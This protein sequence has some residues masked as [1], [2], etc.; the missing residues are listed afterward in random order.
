MEEP[1]QVSEYNENAF[2]IS[3]LHNHWME[4]ARYR[5]KGMLQQVRWK[6]DSIEIELKLDAKEDEINKLDEINKNIK[7]IDIRI[8]NLKKNKDLTEDDLRNLPNILLYDLLK[9]KEEILRDVRQK[10][11][12]GTTYKDLD[13]DEMD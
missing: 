9:Q 8:S 2:Q 7:E 3:R 11:G 4:V 5:E 13:A 12:K 6:L 1:R 10:A